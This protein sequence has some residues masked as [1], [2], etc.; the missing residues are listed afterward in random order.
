MLIPPDSQRTFA[1]YLGAALTLKPEDLPEGG[2]AD[3]RMLYLTGYQFDDPGLRRVAARALDEAR[4]HG[5]K[6]GIDLADVGVIRR[7]RELLAR[8]VRDH[9]EVL[10]ANEPEGLEFTGETDPGRALERMAALAPVACLK[11]AERGSLIRRR[12]R[13]V[14]V[15]PVPAECVD[16][17]GAGDSYAAGVLHG[18]LDDLETEEIG[19]IASTISAHIVSRM[20]ARTSENLRALIARR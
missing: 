13:T 1:T 14:R 4:T 20:G 2:I 6:V 12:G 11:L 3:S 18:L 9:A 19:R 15:A 7:N 8:V 16:T 10:F 17:T 5:V